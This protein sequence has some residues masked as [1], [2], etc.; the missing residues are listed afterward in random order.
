MAG[1]HSFKHVLVRQCVLAEERFGKAIVAE[2]GPGEST[3]IMLHEGAAVYSVEHSPRYYSEAKML[4]PEAVVELIGRGSKG[5]DQG[6]VTHHLINAQKRR[7]NLAFVD[8]RSRIDCARVALLFLPIRGVVLVH[9]AE[10]YESGLLFDEIED[11]T[12][13]IRKEHNQWWLA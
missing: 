8:G 10:R 5:K 12:G 3:R 9:D 6:Y 2:W 7:Y 13:I 1:M 11:G 4:Y